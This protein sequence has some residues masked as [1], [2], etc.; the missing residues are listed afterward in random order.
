MGV[1]NK[2]LE[3]DSDSS[4]SDSSDSDSSDSDSDSYESSDSYSIDND[5]Y[6]SSD[7]S[8]GRDSHRCHTGRWGRGRDGQ[9]TG[10]PG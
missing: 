4:D 10:G 7:S 8:P 6:Y 2:E 3:T 1:R 5:S 9:T